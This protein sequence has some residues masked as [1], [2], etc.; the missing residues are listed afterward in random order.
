MELISRTERLKMQT[1]T[2]IV[3]FGSYGIGK[4]S[5]LKTI[6]EPTLCLDFEAGLLAVQDWEGDSI[7]IRTWNE[8]RDIACLIGGPNPAL[9]AD[10]AYSQRHYEHVSSKYKELSSKLSKY[11]CIFIDSITIASKLC[12]TWA[13]SQPEAFSDKTGRP[14]NRA[15]FGSLASE[16]MN[17]LYQF[18]HIPDKD[19][20]IVGTLGQY[21]DDFNRPT[22]LPQCEGAKT[23]SEIPGIVDEVISMVGIK[24]DDGTEKRSF[25][26]HT[27]NSWGYPAKDRSGCLDMV[28]EPHLGKLL[29]KIKTKFSTATQFAAHN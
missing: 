27:L 14:D 16:M 20:I 9:K 12:L 2:K 6:D 18:Q 1:G 19:I 11:R 5:L 7:S 15:A 13:K 24:K 28:E 17:W 8:A 22:W 3:V 23:A 26:C 4:T 21:L 29:T 10:Q 25:V